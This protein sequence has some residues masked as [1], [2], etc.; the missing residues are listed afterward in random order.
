MRDK[1]LEFMRTQF[2]CTIAT[3]TVD[4]KPGAAYVAYSSNDDM[5]IVV[6]TSSNSRK[7]QNLTRNKSVAIVIA[8]T[9]AEVQYEGEVEIIA[10]GEYRKLVEANHIAKVPGS[11]KYREDPSQ[12][13]LKITPVW[14]RF[15]SHTDNNA[16]EE[17]T[18]F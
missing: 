5:E 9:E 16:V 11:D 15:I 10:D 12:V 7:Y 14:A 4:S 18:E 2:L 6:G 1:M 8:T 3:V 17:F 13:Y